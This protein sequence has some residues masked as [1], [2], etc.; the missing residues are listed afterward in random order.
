MLKKS[1]GKVE[2]ELNNTIARRTRK[3]AALLHP[4][5]AETER[6]A[7]LVARMQGDSAVYMDVWDFFLNILQK[8]FIIPFNSLFLQDS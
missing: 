1:W 3:V 8:A 6:D 5:L 4:Y 2:E 7:P